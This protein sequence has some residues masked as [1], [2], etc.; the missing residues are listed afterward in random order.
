MAVRDKSQGF[1][2][3][4]VDTNKLINQLDEVEHNPEVHPQQNTAQSFHFHKDIEPSPTVDI[5]LEHLKP[6]ESTE[7]KKPMDE[8]IKQIKENLDRL[9][10][11]HHKLFSVLDELSAASRSRKKK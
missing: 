7:K 3:V 8:R 5:K 9:Q 2:F 6:V 11:L 4:F 1:G 10:K